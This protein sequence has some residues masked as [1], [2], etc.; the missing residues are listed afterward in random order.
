MSLSTNILSPLFGLTSSISFGSVPFT[1]TDTDVILLKLLEALEMG[2][3]RESPEQAQFALDTYT[4]K[5]SEAIGE[6]VAMLSNQ[7]IV[8][9]NDDLTYPYWFASYEHTHAALTC[10]Y[11]FVRPKDTWYHTYVRAK[12]ELACL[13]EK[14]HKAALHS[15]VQDSPS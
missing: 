10:E 6:D 14:E 5:V 4:Q 3:V 15:F 1:M 11:H 2:L 8:A 9:Y 12:T 13:S 7:Q